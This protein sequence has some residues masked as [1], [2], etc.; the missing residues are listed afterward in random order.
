L[1]SRAPESF[2]IAANGLRGDGPAQ[3]LRDF[4]VARGANVVTILHPLER[5]DGGR[6]LVTT[7]GDGRLLR[8]RSFR[9]PLSPPLSFAADS[10]VPV[11]QPRIDVWFGFNPLAAWRGLVSRRLGR[12]KRVVLWS[13]DFTPDRFGTGAATRLYDRLD[14]YCCLHADARVELSAAARD[15][16]NARHGVAA[17]AEVVPMGAWLDRLPTTT[18]DGYARRRAVFLGSLVPEKGVDLLIDALAATDVSADIVGGGTRERDVRDH[19]RRRGL[20]ERVRVHGF[21]PDHRDVERILA[22]ASVAVAPYEPGAR[23]TPFADPGKLK[24][25][26]GA[27]LP[28][29]LTA[30]PPNADELAREAGAEIVPYDAAALAAAIE[31][32]VA[33]PETW[34]ER[35]EA[36]LAYSRRFDWN[37]LLEEALPRLGVNLARA[38]RRNRPG[39]PP[40]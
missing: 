29:V 13:V 4:L 20:E 2:A 14:R 36:A 30:V 18:A 39:R 5:D 34:R 24:A 33:A 38:P 6:H 15:A 12:A 11:G 7:Y 32:A 25:Y 31:R 28:T 16:R 35:R 17:P 9:L 10:L 19:V 1:P 8:Q 40:G 27:G 23:Y 21:V 3:A 37:A 22:S 26:V